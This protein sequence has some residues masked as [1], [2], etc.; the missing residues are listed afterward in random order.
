M[1]K[2]SECYQDYVAIKLHFSG[3]YDYQKYNGK[4]RIK[5][6]N[7]TEVQLYIFKKYHQN[8]LGN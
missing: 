7:L 2:T 4:T 3:S 5:G 6:K 8:I 1:Y